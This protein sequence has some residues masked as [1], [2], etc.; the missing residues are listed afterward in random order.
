MDLASDSIKQGRM[1]ETI[2][3]R[4]SEAESG[5]QWRLRDLPDA[6]ETYFLQNLLAENPFQES[7]KNYRDLRLIVRSLDG[8]RDRMTG[9]DRNAPDQQQPNI[10][11]EL[12]IA[13]ARQT[14]SSPYVIMSLA[15]RADDALATPGY[16]DAPLTFD[17]HPVVKLAAVYAPR[18]ANGPFER[19]AAVRGAID[20]L[21]PKL[22]SASADGSKQLE[23]VS[24]RELNGQKKQIER[25]L[26]EARLS[27]AR[28]YDREIKEQPPAPREKKK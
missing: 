11:P 6:P 1:V 17:V 27:V 22:G 24:V 18:N 26:V 8:W 14:Y 19:M 2:V 10:A 12:F 13:R 25:Y 28:I 4:D 21:K 3:R 23:A 15:L 9:F 7:L 16:Y 20:Q 5:W